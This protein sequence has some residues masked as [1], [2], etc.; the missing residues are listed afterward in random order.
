MSDINWV[1][2]FNRLFEMINSGREAYHSGPVFLST[3]MP[4]NYS[5]PSYSVLIEERKELGK[6]TSRKDYFYDL[7][8]SLNQNER[9]E[10]YKIFIT[11]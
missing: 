9:I 8:M 3:I 2:A 7:L 5:I 1:S 10:A 11:N 6:S 4:V